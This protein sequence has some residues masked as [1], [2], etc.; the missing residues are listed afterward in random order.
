MADRMDGGQQEA[1]L[2]SLAS[3]LVAA[4][5]TVIADLQEVMALAVFQRNRYLR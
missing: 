1:M 4:L 5:I 3:G 2:I